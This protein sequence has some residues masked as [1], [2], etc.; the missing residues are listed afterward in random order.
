MK[1]IL[2]EEEQNDE[3]K[4]VYVKLFRFWRLKFDKTQKINF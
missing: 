1:F 4:E 2:R 3:I